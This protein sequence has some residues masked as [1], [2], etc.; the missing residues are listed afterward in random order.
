MSFGEGAWDLWLGQPRPIPPGAEREVG[1]ADP[2]REEAF[3]QVGAGQEHAG[4]RSASGCHRLQSHLTP[5]TPLH[6][7][8]DMFLSP[9]GAS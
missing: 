3:G 7:H 8:L 5:P 6:P 9:R 1:N 4:R 2:R